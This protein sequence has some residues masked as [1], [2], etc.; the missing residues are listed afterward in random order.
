MTT[1][2]TSDLCLLLFLVS[3]SK[4]EN[5]ND[6]MRCDPNVTITG[7]TVKLSKGV[8]V[9]S[10]LRYIC[11]LGFYPYPISSRTCRRY[12]QWSSMRDP[13]R[14][15]VRQAV[16]REFTCPVPSIEQ[17]TLFPN[18]AFYVPGDS[19]TFECDDGCKLLGSAS[20]TC[21]I[22]GRWNGTTSVCEDGL[23][24][25]PNPGTPAGSVK[26]GNNH[27]VDDKV[28]YLCSGDLVL[29]GSSERICLETGEWTGSEPI[30][31]HKHSF[32]L[33]EDV[34]A[35]F[36]ASFSHSLSK[37]VGEK[38]NDA[39]LGR[40]IVLSQGQKLHIYILLDVSGSIEKVDFQRA[41][42][43]VTEFINMISRF[44]VG[45]KYGVIT[46]G[47]RSRTI[48]NIA[49]EWSGF[50]DNVADILSELKYSDY[51][52]DGNTGTNMTG[53][54]KTIYEMMSFQKASMK[55]K[56]SDW[57]EV[58]HVI[59]IFTDG[60]TNMGGNPKP[61]I[62]RIRLFLN[63]G[64]SRED[65]LDVYAFG[66]G[67]DI[68]K[69]EINSIVSKKT[70][71]I[72]AYFLEKGDLTKVFNSM[73][74]LSSVGNLCGFANKSLIATDQSSYPWFAEV[75]NNE[76]PSFRCSGSIVAD[77]WVL[78]AAHCFENLGEGNVNTL[79]ILVG[80]SGKKTSVKVER[81]IKHQRYNLTREAEKNIQEFYDYD[82]ALVKLETK[83]NFT[84]YIRPIC[85]PCT[86]ETSV[87]LRKP[88]AGTTCTDHEKEL[89]PSL[90][91]VEAKFIQTKNRKQDL[92]TVQIKTGESERAL[93]EKDALKAS[94]YVNVT[95]VKAVVTDRFLCTGGS[96]KREEAIACK[97]DSG[98]PLYVQK[99]YR[100]I[101]V[102]VISWGVE[103]LC[104]TFSFPLPLHARDFHVN[105]F[106]VLSWLKQHLGNSTRF[107]DLP[108]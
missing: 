25:C 65:F 60:R 63:I 13:Q 7:G 6:G 73:L 69:A 42:S 88:Q 87:A 48:I 56:Q 66:L 98:G 81:V 22:N 23:D 33:P 105:L 96:R 11:P 1:V 38:K 103:N 2:R 106:E 17:G 78:T 35:L 19:V 77:K 74:D 99:L 108:Q 92:K 37:S 24:T 32:D 75:V 94:I 5:E 3:A 55:D 72:H 104:S 44:E 40:K 67:D 84:T 45:V 18:S 50:A 28:R 82:I 58:R 71:E 101:Q 15:T 64:D 51:K 10:V 79:T 90:G 43:A 14:R 36:S 59:M 86:F 31:Q 80:R 54:L 21:M 85:L 107:L 52:N 53:A 97:G 95:K 93:C 4:G 89:L 8:V 20:R 16:C 39:E 70:N 26:T 62:D 68:D 76:N 30:C 102:G 9:G 46:F 29:I 100:Y 27:A 41:Q 57:N 12:G 34:A 49:D 91:T 47:S 83:L 61:M